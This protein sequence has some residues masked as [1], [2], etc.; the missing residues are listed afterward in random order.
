MVPVQITAA[1]NQSGNSLAAVI[2][3][4]KRNGYIKQLITF[5]RE[6]WASRSV[7]AAETKN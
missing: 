7:T 1:I 2:T 3:N 4:K 6:E 5:L